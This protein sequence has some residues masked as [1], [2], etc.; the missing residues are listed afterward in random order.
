MNA[1]RSILLDAYLDNKVEADRRAHRQ[2]QTDDL[3]SGARCAFIAERNDE[4]VGFACVVG[5]ARRPACRP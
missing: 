2:A 4:T 1:H 3:Q 5:P